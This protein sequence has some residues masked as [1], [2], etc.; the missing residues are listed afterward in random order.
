MTRTLW[1]QLLKNLRVVQY[2]GI[3][4]MM[5]PFGEARRG[6]CYF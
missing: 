6:A 5:D 1:I 3:M 2:C 4:T